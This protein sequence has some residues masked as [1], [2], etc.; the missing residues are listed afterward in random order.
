MSLQVFNFVGYVVFQCFTAFCV[1]RRFA[2]C[3]GFPN[4]HEEGCDKSFLYCGVIMV[5]I[6]A[7]NVCIECMMA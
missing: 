1:L 4:S 7:H 5:L 6:R 2:I 3:S